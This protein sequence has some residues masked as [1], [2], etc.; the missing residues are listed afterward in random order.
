[1][2]DSSDQDRKTFPDSS[3]D[4]A[5]VEPTIVGGRPLTRCQLLKGI[6]RGIEVLIKKASIDPEF[7]AILLE[8]RAEAAT[9]ID[10]DL[11]ATETTMLN[12][13][14]AEQIEKIIGST[15]VPIEHRRVFLGRAAA[16]MLS[17][18]A[19]VGLSRCTVNTGITPDMKPIGPGEGPPFRVS[20]T[21]VPQG[22]EQLA[23]T[24]IEKSPDAVDVSVGFDGPF[25]SGEISISFR[26][27][28]GQRALDITCESTMLLVGKGRRDVTF[29]AI[30]P[31]GETRWIQAELAN[32]GEKRE[33]AADPGPLNR[34]EYQA[35]EFVVEDRLITH[36]IE[37]RKTWKA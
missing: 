7:R 16:A 2:G 20:G 10:L 12:T 25:D 8:K 27:N 9:E 19:G 33:P 30:G 11:S 22:S 3:R 26:Y 17:V 31:S 29:H 18:L 14:P 28:N 1:M 35:G 21:K 23:V 36:I 5:E 4:K 37:V 34:N 13:L 6:P 24:P 15:T 32:R